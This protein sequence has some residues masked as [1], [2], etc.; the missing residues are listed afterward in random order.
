MSLIDTLDKLGG[1]NTPAYSLSIDGVD[2][3]GKLKEKLISLTLTDNRGFEA[4]QINIELDDSEGNL[5]LPRRGVSL[6]VAL[7]WKDTGVI[8]KGTFVVDE[9]GHA[10][11]PDVLTITARSADFRQTLNVQRDASYHKKP[12]G[13]LSEPL[14]AVISWPQS[15]TRMWQT[16]RSGISTKPPSRTAV[17]LPA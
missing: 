15:S 9:I 17:L 2:I 8:D 7:G 10:G 12:L 11:A 13:L 1:D 3:T 14:P 16:F 4:D 6:A 5:K